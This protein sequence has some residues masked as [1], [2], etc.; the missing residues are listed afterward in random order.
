MEGVHLED[1]NTHFV[2]Q[3]GGK[4]TLPTTTS[5]LIG[6]N[7]V[8]PDESPNQMHMELKETRGGH[9]RQSIWIHMRALEHFVVVANIR[10]RYKIHEY[11]LDLNRLMSACTLYQE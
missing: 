7:L 2:I 5:T 3:K 10:Q 1:E 6:Q 9:N 4:H 8:L 11:Y